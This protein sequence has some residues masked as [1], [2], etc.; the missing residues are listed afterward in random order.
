[1]VIVSE[2]N[3]GGTSF[4]FTIIVI[5][6]I[7]FGVAAYF[8]ITKNEIAA[9]DL[10]R[11]E[12]VLI[13]QQKSALQFDVQSLLLRIQSLN[14]AVQ[15]QQL[16]QQEDGDEDQEEAAGQ[17]AELI[18]KRVVEELGWAD[19]LSGDTFFIYKL[20]DMAGGEDFATM[21]FNPSRPELVGQNLSTDFPDA[22]GYDFRKVFMKDIRDHGESF[23]I[24][25]YNKE[26]G[27][28]T[29]AS[30]TGRKLAYFKYD[31]EWEW[32][33]A[34]SVYLD[35]IDLFLAERRAGQK[36]AMLID[37]GIL[38]IIFF[39]SVAL[40]LF[41]AYTLSLGIHE[42]LK[43]YRETEQQNLLEIDSLS[44]TLERQNR[45]DRLTSAYNRSHISQELGKEMARSDRY[46]TPLSMIFF[47]I[48]H[49]RKINDSLGNP[50][51][52]SVLMELADLVKDNIRRTDT[53]ARWG[54]EEFAILAPGIDLT[55]GRMFAEKLRTMIE[56]YRFS[57][58][59]KI[60][61]SFGVSFYKSPE[62]RED[63]VQRTDSALFEAKSRGRN[64]C[65]SL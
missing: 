2:R 6:L 33:V 61:C 23:V 17:A 37:F 57:I 1:M 20:H 34:K 53:L 48:D 30:D 55:H 39:C 31:P 47:D 15:E 21:L 45:T 4:F 64:C 54:G 58:N 10:D 44:K 38:G 52:D 49:F 42:I 7:T 9:R 28:E 60:T 18:E 50:A 51:G 40:A 16:E 41:L 36:R 11:F 35:Q 59:E 43:K 22:R 29:E 3:I 24:Y 62:K 26:P 14:R 19:E 25:W 13:D 8:I 56:A 65:I 46:K 5:S 32:I 12:K 27:E 63:F